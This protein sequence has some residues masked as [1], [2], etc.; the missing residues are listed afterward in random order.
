MYIDKDEYFIVKSDLAEVID[1][2]FKR[3]EIT[4]SN[5]ARLYGDEVCGSRDDEENTILVIMFYYLI[6]KKIGKLSACMIQEVKKETNE[7]LLKNKKISRLNEEE[8]K[9][10]M[11]LVR[12]LNNSDIN[13]LI[14]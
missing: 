7:I 10:F 11:I 1:M 2:V 13:V 8:F 12:E 9:D 5:I 4:I 6:W 14:D 3:R